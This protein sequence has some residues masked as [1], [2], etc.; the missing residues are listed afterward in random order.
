MLARMLAAAAALLAAFAFPAHALERS[1]KALVLA[2]SVTGAGAALSSQLTGRYGAPVHDA[3]GFGLDRL[4]RKIENPSAIGS[5][6]VRDYGSGLTQSQ[7]LAQARD[8][9]QAFA[10]PLVAS[11]RGWMLRNG[12]AMGFFNYEQQVTVAGSSAPMYLVWSAHVG[13][14]GK[15]LYGDPKLVPEAPVFVHAA[16]VSKAVMDGLPQDW[17]YPDAGKLSWRLVDMNFNPKTAWS[18][19]DT[20]GAFDE[21]Q[22]EAAD[23]ELGVKCLVDRASSPGCP[24]GYPDLKGLIDQNAAVGA[25]LDYTRMVQP[26]YDEDPATGDLIARAAISVD[27]RVVSYSSCAADNFA[28]DGRIGFTLQT[29]SDR[30]YASPEG[31]ISQMNQFQALSISPTQSYSHSMALSEDAPD[32]NAR[33]LEPFS[34]PLALQDATASPWNHLVVYLAPL[35]VEGGMSESLGLMSSPMLYAEA[36]CDASRP[37]QIRVRGI[38]PPGEQCHAG[39]CNSDYFWVERWFTRGQAAYMGSYNNFISQKAGNTWTQPGQTYSA[40]NYKGYLWEPFGIAYDGGSNVY[41]YGSGAT[42]Y[43]GRSCTTETVYVGDGGYSYVNVCYDT[44]SYAPPLPLD[45]SSRSYSYQSSPYFT[46]GPY[47]EYPNDNGGGG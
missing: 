46:S 26:V 16:Y 10:P 15:A 47:Y 43:R 3:A 29:T 27:R 8:H 6:P 39:G 17:A 40:R 1:P 42:T 13:L 20:G 41:F 22:G 2:Q 36:S 30:Y 31:A 44:T 45:G 23:P 34:S 9:F 19:I 12:V 37:G 32:L 5:M 25:I 18:V 38:I 33:F 24:A 14:D 4:G 21:P 35:T 7:I 11:L 28:N